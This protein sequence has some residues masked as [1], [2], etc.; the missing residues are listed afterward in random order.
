MR[1]S[2]FSASITNTVNGAG[3]SRYATIRS[4]VSSRAFSPNFSIASASSMNTT[5]C[6]DS[7][8]RVCAW[9]SAIG[10]SPRSAEKRDTAHVRAPSGTNLSINAARQESRRYGSSPSSNSAGMIFPFSKRSLNCSRLSRAI[11]N[12]PSPPPPSGLQNP[13]PCDRP[14]VRLPGKTIPL[15]FSGQKQQDRWYQ[16]MART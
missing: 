12:S 15:G 3:S 14:P 7:I 11:N 6:D 10:V 2:N 13:G 16:K 1:I 8:G 9:S 5:C 4:T